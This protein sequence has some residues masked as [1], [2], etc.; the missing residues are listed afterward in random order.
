M[1]GI[2]QI[3]SK[4]KVLFW[5]QGWPPNYLHHA[6]AV[7]L[8]KRYGVQ[9]FSGFVRGYQLYEFLKNQ[10]EIKY[11]PIV[12]LQDIFLKSLKLKIDHEYLASL[13]KEYGLPTLWM[14]PLAD[15]DMLTF[16]RYTS[17]THEELMKIIQGYFKYITELLEEAKPDFIIM[18]MAENMGLL[19]L[20][21]VAKRMKIPTLIIFPTRIGDRI[22]I[23]RNT[24]DQWD[25]IYEIYDRLMKK[26]YKSPYKKDAVK[27]IKEFRA[28]GGTY[29]SYLPQYA[30][31]QEFYTSILRTPFKTLRRA[32]H[33]FYNY[34]FGYLK[35]DFMYKNKSP[36]KL[37]LAEL[38]I[39]ARRATLKNSNIFEKPD[40]KEQYVYFPLHFEPEIATMLL[41]P[42]YIDQITL[43]ENIAKSLPIN[44]KLYV[45]EHPMM[46]G[47]RPVSSYER[48][49]KV[50]NIR[51][52]D[53]STPSYE[54]S[55]N[56]RLVTTITGTSGWEAL[57]FKKPVITFGRVFYNKLDMVIKIKDM[58]SLPE[59][60]HDALENYKHDEE[61]L[62]NFVAAVFEGSFSARLDIGEGSLEKTLSHPDFN[63][64]MDALARE[65]GLTHVSPKSE[66]S[67]LPK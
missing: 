40:Y 55:K 32:L 39:R 15:R 2:K 23:F 65:M 16:N 24:F 13:E 46:F 53:P 58:T 5:F 54:L 1:G 36:L 52:I 12:A 18:P 6:I 17:Y 51:L 9:N 43:I 34:H 50:P 44:F 67:S 25:K 62:T 57:M 26:E 10:K 61:Q 59:L 45:K 64:M 42:F 31:L 66:A 22:A 8:K 56:A 63:V 28:R 47:L 3:G 21:E 20:H 4:M 33:Y 60:V 41:A 7:T 11:E 49:S 27:Y 37:A 48:L 14:Y 29:S 38:E 30:G 35:N 19:V